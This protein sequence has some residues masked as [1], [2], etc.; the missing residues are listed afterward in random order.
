MS[1]SSVY[2]QSNNMNEI[3]IGYL[4]GNGFLIQYKKQK[5]DNKYLKI[6]ASSAY[7]TIDD[8]FDA[9]IGI[10]G[11]IGLENRKKLN[12]KLTFLRGPELFINTRLEFWEFDFR[13]AFG[14]NFGILYSI[15][16]YINFGASLVPTLGLVS[17]SDF[18]LIQAELDLVTIRLSIS[19]ILRM[20]KE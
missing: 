20:N 14:Y 19:Y 17:Y 3:G 15:G 16:P 9:D 4:T 8:H 1:L 5:S 7:T 6:T 10:A 2:G 11:S 18:D 13:I 12:E